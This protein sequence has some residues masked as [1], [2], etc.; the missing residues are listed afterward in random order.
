[1]SRPQPRWPVGS[2]SN[3]QPVG[4]LVNC[5]DFVASAKCTLFLIERKKALKLHP[6]AVERFLACG[7]KQEELMES[8]SGLLKHPNLNL[9]DE[10]FLE[11]TLQEEL[12]HLQRLK[13]DRI[14]VLN[15]SIEALKYGL[16]VEKD[17]L[18]RGKGHEDFVAEVGGFVLCVESQLE[19]A[20][21]EKALLEKR[22]DK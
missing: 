16:H 6:F 10:T 11:E 14:E 19:K 21:L 7:E 1:M 2:Y 9:H 5:F 20:L 8:I 12:Q 3:C 22:E 4:R 13:L 18:A 17:R 15:S